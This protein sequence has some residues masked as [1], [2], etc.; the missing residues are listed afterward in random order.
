MDFSETHEKLIESASAAGVGLIA[1]M[2]SA[3]SKYGTGPNYA[4]NAITK[5][6]FEDAL[7]GLIGN[8]A[9]RAIDPTWTGGA[10]FHPNALGWLNKGFISGI[11][12]TIADAFLTEIKQYRDLPGV[13]SVV[14]GAAW[15]LILGS[16]IGG[17]F[18]PDPTATGAS[19]VDATHGTNLTLAPYASQVA[20]LHAAAV[21]AH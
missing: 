21:K 18:D 8:Q 12:L 16:A 6:R 15:G 7:A 11:A 3:T 1:W 14:K 19:R 2:Y 5:W 17:I 20:A 10:T 13:H 9:V 4:G